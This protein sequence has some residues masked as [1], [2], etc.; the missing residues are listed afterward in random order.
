MYV[1]GFPLNNDVRY[2]IIFDKEPNKADI[3]KA[4]AEMIRFA[5]S[6]YPDSMFATDETNLSFFAYSCVVKEITEEELKNINAFYK[7]AYNAYICIGEVNV[8]VYDFD[9]EAM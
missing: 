7:K 6:Y 9:G 4:V 8:T 1:V 2:N 5:N 3:I